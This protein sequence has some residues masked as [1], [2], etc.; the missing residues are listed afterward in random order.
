[1]RLQEELDELKQEKEEIE[2]NLKARNEEYYQLNEK[3]IKFEQIV[4]PEIQGKL[5]RANEM[6]SRKVN[7]LIRVKQY[8]ERLRSDFFM[9]SSYRRNGKVEEP[10]PDEM[11]LEASNDSD[12]IVNDQISSTL[13]IINKIIES[14]ISSES[15][16]DQFFSLDGKMLDRRESYR[17]SKNEVFKYFRNGYY[18]FQ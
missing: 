13:D 11:M 16:E 7:D 9:L 4:L 17:Y 5:D 15:P 8:I 6:N 14:N 18:S 12:R 10:N 3:L 2:A 1:M